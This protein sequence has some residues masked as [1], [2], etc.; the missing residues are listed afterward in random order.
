MQCS[1]DVIT[2]SLAWS[3]YTCNDSAGA[4]YHWLST[5]CTSNDVAS[6]QALRSAYLKRR[7]FNDASR[8]QTLR[9]HAPL[10]MPLALQLLLQHTP[11][12]MPLA[13]KLSTVGLVKS[14]LWRKRRMRDESS[15]VA[16]SLSV[17][18]GDDLSPWQAAHHVMH[19]G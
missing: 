12:M 3:L 19:T 5:T 2:S 9:Q 16:S 17:V 4:C 1:Y 13:L 11:L 15:P 14:H 18:A 8:P 6:L 10:M 7:I